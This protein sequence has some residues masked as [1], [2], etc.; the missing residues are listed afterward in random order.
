MQL[1]AAVTYAESKMQ[2]RYWAKNRQ[3]GLINKANQFMLILLLI[4]QTM[5]FQF[6]VVHRNF[7]KRLLK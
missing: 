7:L 3:T 4:V 2:T 6:L 1:Y 5:E